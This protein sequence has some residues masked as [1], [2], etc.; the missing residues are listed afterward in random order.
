MSWFLI[1]RVGHSSWTQQVNT[2][3]LRSVNQL[4]RA[5]DELR[6]IPGL[7]KQT[8]RVLHGQRGLLPSTGTG[9]K[10]HVRHGQTHRWPTGDRQVTDTW[11]DGKTR[12][13]ACGCTALP[14][15]SAP[16]NTAWTEPCH[17]SGIQNDRNTNLYF[18]VDILSSCNDQFNEA[19]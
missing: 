5:R 2:I 12:R 17:H 9:R 19:N 18:P 7:G 3:Y 16:R 10:Y 11:L 4:S 6:L 1:V 13:S 15:P 8:G 14:S